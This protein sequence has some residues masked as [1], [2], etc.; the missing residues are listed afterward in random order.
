MKC[1]RMK[2]AIN[3]NVL[4]DSLKSLDVASVCM[5]ASPLPLYRQPNIPRIN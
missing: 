3:M 2:N 1:G 5:D 4:L